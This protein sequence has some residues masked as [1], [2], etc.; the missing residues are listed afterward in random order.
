[1][2]DKNEPFVWEGDIEV[3]RWVRHTH[4]DWRTL[5]A[6]NAAMRLSNLMKAGYGGYWA[7][8]Y[9]APGDQL[10]SI[11]EALARLRTLLQET[12]QHSQPEA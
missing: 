8:E 11:E 9:N 1:M 4:V 7:V 2:A 10:A 6:P 3:A 5:Q 12:G